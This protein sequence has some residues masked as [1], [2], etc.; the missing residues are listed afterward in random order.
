M[1][2]EFEAFRIFWFI[3]QS[4]F[5]LTYIYYMASERLQGEEQFHSKNYLFEMH[6]CHAKIRFKSAPQKLNFLMATDISKSYTLDCSCRLVPLHVPSQLRIVMQPH[7]RYIPFYVKIPIFFFART[8]ESW[9]KWTLDS[10][11]T[12]KRK[13]GYLWQFRKFCLRQQLCAFKEFC[14]ET[15]LSNIFKTTNVTNF[16]KAILKSSYRVL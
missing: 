15:R 13:R 3:W 2:T 9:V 4:I 10:Q 7:F 5:S 12:F 6:Y 1:S 16:T 8:I 11:R 14:M